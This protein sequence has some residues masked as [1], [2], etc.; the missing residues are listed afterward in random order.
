MAILI[1]LLIGQCW[2]L[3]FDIELPGCRAKTRRRDD[4]WLAGFLGPLMTAGGAVYSLA[5][6]ESLFNMVNMP[7]LMMIITAAKTEAF[8]QQTRR[9]RAIVRC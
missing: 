2:Y 4:E 9:A 7:G 5:M 8:S 6:G 1:R 3:I